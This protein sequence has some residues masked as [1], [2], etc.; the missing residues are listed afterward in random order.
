MVVGIHHPGMEGYP[1]GPNLDWDSSPTDGRLPIGAHIGLGFIRHH[2]QDGRV[3][4]RGPRLVGI[5]HPG[6]VGIA[7]PQIWLGLR[8]GAPDWLR[9]GFGAEH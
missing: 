1:S 8:V 4:H 5:H 7:H 2:P 6:L 3:T 9:H